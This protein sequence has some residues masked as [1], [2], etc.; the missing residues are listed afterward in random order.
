MQKYT[1]LEGNKTNV[2]N[3]AQA[4]MGLIMGGQV[5]ENSTS[6]NIY[7]CEA[8]SSYSSLLKKKCYFQMDRDPSPVHRAAKVLI[9]SQLENGDFPQQV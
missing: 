2:V 7:I 1:P 4:M 5:S 9:N 3:T 8:L 6:S